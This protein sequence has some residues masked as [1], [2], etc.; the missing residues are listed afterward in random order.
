MSTKIYNG[1]R[2]EC[3]SLDQVITSLLTMRTSA[4]NEIFKSIL[5]KNLFLAVNMYDSLLV[6][7]ILKPNKANLKPN[8]SE[9]NKN[10]KKFIPDLTKSALSNAYSK[11]L[12]KFW[13]NEDKEDDSN[14]EIKVVVFPTAVDI[15]NKKNY[16][17]CLYA[18][19]NLNDYV[20][21]CW[22]DLGIKEY[23]Y[24]NNT[25]EPEGITLEQWNLRE[26]H[27]DT[28]LTGKEKT[29]IPSVEGLSLTLA[30][31]NQYYY[32]FTTEK[33]QILLA[34]LIAENQEKL[35]LDRRVREYFE[36]FMIS[37]IMAELLEHKGMDI[38]PDNVTNEFVQDS[39]DCYFEAKS[40][41]KGKQYS[42]DKVNLFEKTKIE[43]TERLN[44]PILL[45]DLNQ[46][47]EISLNTSLNENNLLLSK[48]KLK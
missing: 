9:N 31:V 43:L 17:L 35:S 8:S 37:T 12:K 34:E 45:E 27:W 13:D 28:V 36:E 16:L 20:T 39:L 48:R 4:K 21:S 2:I 26:K 1:Y 3:D 23:G 5:Q 15:D 6:E 38:I 22:E 24:W 18:D 46:P 44:Y 14:I 40:I 47:L 33:S 32:D 42:E 25:D 19:R 30:Q 7:D 29:G 11:H 10:T 41:V